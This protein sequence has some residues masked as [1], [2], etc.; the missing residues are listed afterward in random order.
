[1]RIPE[2]LDGNAILRNVLFSVKSGK[3]SSRDIRDF[4]FAIERD[5]AACGVFITLNPPTKDMLKEA[6]AAGFYNSGFVNNI[7]KIK[8]VTIEQ[9]LGGERTNLPYAAEAVKQARAAVAQSGQL[10]FEYTVDN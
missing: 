3:V 10:G 6:A 9:M 1:M 4:G 2:N 5:N 7:D 8:I